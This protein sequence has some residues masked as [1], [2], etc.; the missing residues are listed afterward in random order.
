ML[1]DAVNLAA[2]LEGINKQ[3]KTY[4]MIS[5]STLD[6][7]GS[8]FPVRELS[9]VAV[10]GRKEPVT[11]YEPMLEEVRTYHFCACHRERELSLVGVT[12]TGVTYGG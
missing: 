11:V 8:A 2:R 5:Q 9:R 12:E 6:H 3:F 4:T 1:G 7:V 10:V